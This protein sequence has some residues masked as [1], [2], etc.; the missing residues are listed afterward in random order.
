[1]LVI[2]G[3]RCIH[4]PVAEPCLN[5]SFFA[6][7]WPF[8][9]KALVT[10]DVLCRWPCLSMAGEKGSAIVLDREDCLLDRP[11]RPVLASM[12]ACS[13]QRK[14]EVDSTPF[15]KRKS[16]PLFVPGCRESSAKRK[17][18][19]A[20]VC[21]APLECF[22]SVSVER[23]TMSCPQSQRQPACREVLV[24]TNL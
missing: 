24:F 6:H 12:L 15:A 21:C 8:R 4:C 17:K 19:I 11:G 1:M 3:V 7:R 16:S 2:S 5:A 23:F 22:N 10:A 20:R 9:S 18:V 14:Y 13:R